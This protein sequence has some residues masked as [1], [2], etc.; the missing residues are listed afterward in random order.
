MT[1]DEWEAS[2]DPTAMLAHCGSLSARKLRLF[3]VACCRRMAAADAAVAA[4]YARVMDAAERM[5]EG[6]PRAAREAGRLRANRGAVG[7]YSPRWAASNAMWGL[8]ENDPSAAADVS[9]S[10]AAARLQLLAQEACGY[11]DGWREDAARAVAAE[12]AAQVVL[13][14]CVAGNPHRPIAFPAIWRTSAALSIAERAYAD[15]DSATL[16]FLAD[17]IE[18][19]GCQEAEVLRHLREPATHAR[20]CWVV[21]LLLGRS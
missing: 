7:G 4:V 15:R 10:Y 17:A 21:D 9:L 6:K 1:A 13:L 3:A 2:D 8:L 11:D 19:D 16:P 14:R 12:R 18:D 5:A 20:G